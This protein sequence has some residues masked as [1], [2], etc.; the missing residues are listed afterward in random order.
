MDE[1][2]PASIAVDSLD[3]GLAIVDPA[4]KITWA[5]ASWLDAVTRQGTLQEGKALGTLADLSASARGAAA[6]AI[7]RGIR[8]VIEGDSVYFELEYRAP[9]QPPRRFVLTATPLRGESQGAVVMHRELR[10]ADDRRAPVIGGV[11][12][13]EMAAPVDRLTPRELQIL[14]LL[15]RGLPNRDIA[16]ELQ[17][18]Y[19]TVRG[20]VQTII[21]KFGAS[22]RLECVAMAY[23][24]G[25][26]E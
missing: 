24:L 1:R 3:V 14:R 15:A 19:T 13:A 17:I 10:S 2:D 5:N 20:Y 22:S 7:E 18:E 9:T 16:R 11:R 26:V 8:S 23:R 25:M 6:A 21:Q 4:G 12:A